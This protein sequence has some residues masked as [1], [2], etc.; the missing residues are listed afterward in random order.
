MTIFRFPLARITVAFIAGII[1]A[2]YIEAPV[3][4]LL[5][6]AAAALFLLILLFL[7]ARRDL[8]Q[9]I[10]F[11]TCVFLLAGVLGI[12]TVAI[13]SSQ[14]QAEHYLHK[15]TEENQQN[16]LRVLIRGRLKNTANYS[17]YI[18]EVTNIE[19]L[20]CTGSI[21]IN[22]RLEDGSFNYVSGTFLDLTA[23]IHQ[24]SAPLNPDQFDYGKY[25]SRK[26]IHAQ[27]Y[28]HPDQIRQVPVPKTDMLHYADR[29]RSTITSNLQRSGFS[30]RELPVLSALV[31]GQRQD[32]SA[33]IIRDYQYAGAVHILAVSGL[34]VGLVLLLLNSL[35]KALPPNR[36]TSLAKLLVVIFVLWAF[37][38][39]A[40]LSPSV[41]RAVTM[42]TFVAIGMHMNRSTNIYHTLLVSML[43]ILLFQPAFIYDV[44]FQLSYTALFS[45]LWLQP[46]LMDLWEPKHRIIRYFW[47][48]LTVSIAAQIGAFPISIFYF[49]Q[50]PALFFI[51]NLIIIPFLGV[52]MAYGILI[53]IIAAIG[54][55]PS[56]LIWGLENCIAAMNFI[57]A[58]IASAD[59]FVITNIP[60][61]IYL[62]LTI[63]LL[64]I[65]FF[66][67][68]KKPDFYRMAAAL[69]AAVILSIAFLGTHWQHE[70]LQQWMIFQIRN[71][72]LIVER[73]GKAASVVADRE[74]LTEYEQR[75]LQSY[76]TANYI[77]NVR[78]ESA[79]NVRVFKNIKILMVDSTAVYPE[80]KTDVLLLTQSPKINLDRLISSTQPEV[81][82]ADGSNFRS[83]KNRWRTTCAKAKIPF[84]DTSEKGY[85]KLQ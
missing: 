34:H 51:T 38:I 65:T 49:H 45:I 80:A 21:L 48:I 6:I 54:Y 7:S 43:V 4:R 33:D 41:V 44:G 42:F 24:H 17:R 66:Y 83:Y 75:V 70:H 39:I 20:R 27:I 11:G 74:N 47:S 16:K 62:L 37:A 9:R 68:I 5:L 3:E 77:E 22:I 73:S 35:L 52:I 14:N 71:K 19:S 67:W 78:Y 13:N 2:E 72:T 79:S 30:S 59:S 69:A 36:R 8:I 23:E 82:V 61:N 56:M 31:L 32:L 60:L 28:C 1:I 29:L 50:F 12:L 53:M 64:L 18:A 40:S 55:V 76:L 15:I 57:I 85:Y 81:V 46:L 10:Y 26:N 58:K 84:H 25:L 63:Y